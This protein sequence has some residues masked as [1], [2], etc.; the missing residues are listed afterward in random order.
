M[1]LL[2]FLCSPF[3]VAIF[4]VYFLYD[5]GP[6]QNL[7]TIRTVLLILGANVYPSSLVRSAPFSG[8]FLQFKISNIIKSILSFFKALFGKFQIIKIRALL[9]SYLKSAEGRNRTLWETVQ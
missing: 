6:L 2:S 8:Q 1:E 5:T 3:V 7:L 4:R 9:M